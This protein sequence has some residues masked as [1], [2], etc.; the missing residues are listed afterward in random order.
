MFG[1]QK[2]E[3]KIKIKLEKKNRNDAHNFERK[4]KKKLK[5][6]ATVFGT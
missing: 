3:V 4:A 1:E 6:I 5:M 2:P